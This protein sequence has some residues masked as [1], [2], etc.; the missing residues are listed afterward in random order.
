[1]DV[2]TPEL[3]K[4]ETV[5]LK[6]RKKEEDRS[7]LFQVGVT[8]LLVRDNLWQPEDSGRNT[9]FQEHCISV[10]TPYFSQGSQNQLFHR[11]KNG[12]SYP[13]QSVHGL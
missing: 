3:K 11:H 9:M 6:K 2:L 4:L 5:K 12:L 13:S 1:M 7:S 8:I 10:S